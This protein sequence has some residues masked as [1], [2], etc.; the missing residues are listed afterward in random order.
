MILITGATGTNGR[1]IVAQLSA[2]GVLEPFCI[3]GDKIVAG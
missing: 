3:Y 1:K 2:K